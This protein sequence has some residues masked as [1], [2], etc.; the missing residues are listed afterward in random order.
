MEGY[1]PSTYGEHIADVYDDWYSGVEEEALAFLTALASGGSALEL[2]IGTGRLAI[3]LKAR[4]VTVQG[5]DASPSMV[6]HLRS[7]PG[8][9][10][11]P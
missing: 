11:S 6:Q 1:E 9:R 8:G 5:I 7:K 3:P 4:G 10:P 2:G